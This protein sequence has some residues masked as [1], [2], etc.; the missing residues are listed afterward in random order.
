MPQPATPVQ[1]A[2]SAP[3][4][5]AAPVSPGN[6]GLLHL[7]GGPLAFALSLLLPLEGV[8][9]AARGAVGLLVW[10]AWWWITEPVDLAVTALLPL[11]ATA[12]FGLAPM[13]RVVTAYAE[14]TIILLLGANVL[15][16]VWSLWGLD[17]RI[18]LVSLLGVGTSTNRQI[19]VWFLIAAGLSAVLPNTIVAATMCPIVVAMLRYIG[20][21]D[22]KESRLG[23]A[24]ILAIAWGTSAGGAGTPLGGAPNLIT[25]SA[26]EESITG[27]EFLFVTWVTRLLPVTLAIV[28]VMYLFMRSAMKPEIATIPGS[29]DFFKGELRGLGPLSPQ[30]RWGLGL[31]LAA[32]SLAFGRPLFDELLPGLTPSYAFITMAVIAFAARSGGKPLVTWSYAQKNMMWGLFYLF[33]GG[34]A[35]GRILEESGAARLVADALV[36]YAGG[37]GFVAVAVFSV[38]TMIITQITSNTAAVAIAVPITIST[39]QTLGMNPIPYVYIVTIVGNCG[40]ILPSS[41]GGPAVAAGYGINL[42]TMFTKG[43]Q[44]S[45]LVLVLLLVLGYLLAMF[46]PAFGEA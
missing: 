37:G 13:N 30:E 28:L 45:A 5:P 22:L 26:I 25:V 3:T 8:P 16:S 34:I 35:L 18:A 39:F 14:D 38:L 4:A 32:T 11:V 46:W 43:L 42:R 6:G 23:T 29:K 24:L 17:R 12:L 19:L 20:I 21:E 10:M 9:L 2:R 40:F 33:A 44:A 41:A 7:I 15:T 31:F 27:Q 1:Q 36:P